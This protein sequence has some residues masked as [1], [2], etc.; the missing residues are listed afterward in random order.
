MGPV[1]AL[2][3]TGAVSVIG[4]VRAR[5][6]R[7]IRADVIPK[8]DMDALL[9]RKPKPPR[10][11]EVWLQNRDNVNGFFVVDMLVKVFGIT[12][13]AAWRLCLGAHGA[14]ASRVVELPCPEAQEKVQRA[15]ALARAEQPTAVGL[16]ELR[17]LR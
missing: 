10:R 9:E 17:T 16:L 3:L 1:V 12:R 14:G 8:L 2:L 4:G 6:S 15:D 11:C 13:E 5:G 7:F